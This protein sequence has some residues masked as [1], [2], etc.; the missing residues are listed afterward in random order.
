MDAICAE[1]PILLAN[2]SSMKIILDQCNLYLEPAMLVDIINIW[3]I[4]NGHIVKKSNI[5][6]LMS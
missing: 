6:I 1:Y 3:N 5:P 2:H 4:S